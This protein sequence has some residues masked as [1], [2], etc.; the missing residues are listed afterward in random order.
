[1]LIEGLAFNTIIDFL[2]IN[3]YYFLVYNNNRLF[4]IPHY[5]TFQHIFLF[6]LTFLNGILITSI[7]L[8]HKLLQ[9]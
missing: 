6:S 9:A 5:L 8:I 2:Q 1:M 3:T 4:I 7:Y